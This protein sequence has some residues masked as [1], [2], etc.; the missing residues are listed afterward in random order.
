MIT[1]SNM[2]S[3]DDRIQALTPLKQFVGSWR[4]KGWAVTPSGCV[5]FDQTEEVGYAAGGE[6]LTIEGSGSHPDDAAEVGFRAFAVVGFDDETACL[7][8]H[9]FHAGRVV[10]V[11]L[12]LTDGGCRWAFCPHPG[13]T[14]QF[15]ISVDC[16]TWSETGY[17]STDGEATW[18]QTLGM[19]LSQCCASE[20]GTSGP[21]TPASSS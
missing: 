19:T 21:P 1:R 13:V 9:A 11:S 8:W 7:R 3:H 20:V 15:D 17:T 2:G 5:E 14:I 16:D 4:G 12:E 18:E 6:L 10:N